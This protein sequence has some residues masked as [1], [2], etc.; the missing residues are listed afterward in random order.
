MNVLIIDS[1]GNQTVYVKVMWKYLSISLG[2]SQ[3]S[4]LSDNTAWPLQ[5]NPGSNTL[6]HLEQSV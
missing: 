1:F 2:H 5:T 6:D 4:F 3:A